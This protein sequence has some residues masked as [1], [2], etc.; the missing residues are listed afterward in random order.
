MQST[1]FPR[2]KFLKGCVLIDRIELL[3]SRRIPFFTLIPLLLLV[4]IGGWFYV[5]IQKEKAE[6]VALKSKIVTLE[7]RLDGLDTRLGSLNT[8]LEQ[9]K[10][11]EIDL[12]TKLKQFLLPFENRVKVAEYS[13]PISN[14]TKE[15]FQFA[16]DSNIRLD[17]PDEFRM[18]FERYTNTVPPPEVQPWL[19][20]QSQAIGNLLRL[21]VDS[22]A[23]SLD[24]FSRSLIPRESGDSPLAID[25]LSILRS[26][27]NL[28]F[29]ADHT[30]HDRF[31]QSLSLNR[32]Y[33][34][35]VR[36][37]LHN[38]ID[39]SSNNQSGPTSVSMT[40]EIVCLP[41]KKR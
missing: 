41:V 37:D 39:G 36:K 4:V 25:K 16:S 27:V 30:V 35:I 26:S 24:S 9:K 13:D 8:K 12:T 22:G 20:Y 18:G 2:F 6:H 28:T 19:I 7:S 31:V 1:P 32:N 23:T 29:Q 40:I 11:T 17:L 15:F 21:L 38:F 3:M 10:Q 14:D 5:Q 34:Y 33:F